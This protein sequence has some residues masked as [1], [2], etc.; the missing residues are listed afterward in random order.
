MAE[1]FEPADAPPE[2]A[3]DLVAGARKPVPADPAALLQASVSR[4]LALAGS[5]DGF[6]DRPA[7][8]MPEV[9][10]GDVLENRFQILEELGFGAT[11]TTFLAD[12]RLL[13]KVA[14]K[15]LHPELSAI[16]GWV[17]RFAAEIRTARSVRH[18]NVCAVYDLFLFESRDGRRAAATMEYLRGETLA[19]RM[20][21][22]T[23]SPPEAIRIAK[24]VAAG[25]DALHAHGVLHRDLKP[26]NI[27]LVR[28]ADRSFRP[29]I[30]DF[31]LASA[32][33]PQV[34]G[35]CAPGTAVQGSPEYM[36]PE[37]FRPGSSTKASDIYAFGLILFEMIAGTRPFP[38]EDLLQTAIRR[39]VEDAPAIASV[40]PWV[41]RAWH[42]P[43]SRALS[44]DADRRPGSAMDLVRE[45][46]GRSDIPDREAVPIA[47]RHRSRRIPA[48]RCCR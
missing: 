23:I 34:R 43:I 8:A 39:S 31:G 25:I 14:L 17:S 19:R 47:R 45:I 38:R 41:P 10:P 24:G 35:T 30:L 33:G 40:A 1:R 12:D 44:R 32:G 18:A 28:N 27:M 36:A 26:D 46:E 20:S 6:L 9:A 4:L 3:L 21:R 7:A 15:V 2:N 16:D 13:G 42:A 11:A 29:V 5:A 48:R 22:C 37:Q